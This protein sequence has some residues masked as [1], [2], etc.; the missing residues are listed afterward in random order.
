MQA[1]GPSKLNIMWAKKVPGCLWTFLVSSRHLFEFYRL[2]L[3]IFVN[4]RSPNL[5]RSLV[6]SAAETELG[7]K[8]QVEI[9]RILQDVDEVFRIEL[10]SIALKPLDQDVCRDLA[11]KRDVIRCLAGK[12]FAKGIL[13]FENHARIA[14]N[15]RHHLRHDDAGGV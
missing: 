12:I 6:F 14:G 4:R 11:L 15:H 13:V 1:Q 5:V 3:S 9:A 10:R 8:A 2:V 7:S